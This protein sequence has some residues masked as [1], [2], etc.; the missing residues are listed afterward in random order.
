MSRLVFKGDKVPKKKKLKRKSEQQEDIETDMGWI[1]VKD[2]NEIQGPVAILSN[3]LHKHLS[4][5]SCDP[6]NALYFS[7]SNV[8]KLKQAEPSQANQVFMA[9][10][11]SANKILFKSCFNRHLG[12]D[13][14]GNMNCDREAVDMTQEWEIIQ[15]ED[16]F[17]FKSCFGKFLSAYNTSDEGLLKDVKLHC[18]SETAGIKETFLLICQAQVVQSTAQKNN[19]DE[20]ADLIELQLRKLKKFHSHT[21]G[22]L[23]LGKE[24]ANVSDMQEAKKEGR[25]HEALVD[26]RIKMKTD[27]VILID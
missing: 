27:K 10:S 9:K 4:F 14:Q 22:K 11:I 26:K 25:I 21:L 23:D 5:L 7:S 18:T 6:R 1:P 19:A 3:T 8:S 15:K 13:K 2:L 12:S 20:D 16:G 24:F 17:A